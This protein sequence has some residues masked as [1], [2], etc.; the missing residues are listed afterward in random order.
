MKLSKTKKRIQALGLML[1]IS[2]LTTN[3]YATVLKTGVSL[4]AKKSDLINVIDGIAKDLKLEPAVVLATYI[5]LGGAV[6]DNELAFKVSGNSWGEDVLLKEAKKVS[7]KKL[8]VSQNSKIKEDDIDDIRYITYNNAELEQECIAIYT[9]TKTSTSNV[10]L[11][12]KQN[13]LKLGEFVYNAWVNELNINNSSRT[14]QS[15]NKTTKFNWLVDR[16]RLNGQPLRITSQ[17]AYRDGGEMHR[18]LDFATKEFT[19]ENG[20]VGE[21]NLY[22]VHDGTVIKAQTNEKNATGLA[23]WYEFTD[24]LGDKYSVSYMHLSSLGN[25]VVGSKVSVDTVL[26]TTGHTGDSTGIHIHIQVD[27]N[28]QRINPLRLWGYDPLASEKDREK[29]V[30]DNNLVIPCMGECLV[31]LNYNNADKEFSI[32]KCLDHRTK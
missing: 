2:S 10:T 31:D 22:P 27:R 14:V 11:Q 16:N 8:S 23:V 17:Y 5:E 20:N 9:G 7:S 12:L 15:A 30:D 3:T 28:G 24:E 32:V 29:W 6:L 26:G 18:A 19:G 25:I 21:L 4:S 1:I 13:Y